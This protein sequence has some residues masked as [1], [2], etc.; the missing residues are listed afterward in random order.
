M[1]DEGDREI[2]KVERK[3]FG[4]MYLVMRKVVVVRTDCTN[5]GCRRFGWGFLGRWSGTS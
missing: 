4:S 3:S 2:G 1:I 5:T